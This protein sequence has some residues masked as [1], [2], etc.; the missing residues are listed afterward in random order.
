MANPSSSKGK[1]RPVAPKLFELIEG[2]VYGDLWQREQLSRRDRSLI[3]LAA[4]IAMRQTDQ[5]RSH[6]EK[7]LDHGV[8]AE[9]IG[10]M[11]T[12][13]SIYA[14]FPAAISAALTAKPLLA[15]L[16]LIDEE[17]AT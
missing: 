13:L 1:I 14:G 10:E 12:H 11:I 7:A 4:L 17:I 5:M 2:T 3:T 16:G 9:E 6:F 15:E 8:T